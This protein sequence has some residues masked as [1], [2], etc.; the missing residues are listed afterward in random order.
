M[1]ELH[2]YREFRSTLVKELGHELFGPRRDDSDNIREEELDISPLQIY[3]CG[4]LFP[5]KLPQNAL[6]D[7]S[8][9]RTSGIDEG[10]DPEGI[11]GDLDDVAL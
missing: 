5:R 1:P 4:I 8:E 7:S 3:G 10:L 2:E 11:D 6:E 9:E